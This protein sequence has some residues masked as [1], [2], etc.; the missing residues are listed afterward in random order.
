MCRMLNHISKSYEGESRAG[1][2]SPEEALSLLK[3]ADVTELMG[4]ADRIAWISMGVM[5]ILCT[6]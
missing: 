4:Y 6:A 5:F 3:N 1:R 2:I